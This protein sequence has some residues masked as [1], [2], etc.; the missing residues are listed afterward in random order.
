MV[1]DSTCRPS[2]RSTCLVVSRTRGFSGRRG[3]EEQVGVR[4]VAEP[5]EPPSSLVMMFRR[6]AILVRKSARV[7]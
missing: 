7:L 6:L 3:T 2:A 4:R 1:T 5:H